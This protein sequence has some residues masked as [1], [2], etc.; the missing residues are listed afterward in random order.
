M[1]ERPGTLQIRTPEGISFS[2]ILASPISRMLAWLIDFA[3]IIGVAGLLGK[4]ASLLS[5]VSADAAEGVYL[6]L[7]FAFSISYGIALEWRWRGQTV[8]KRALRLRVLD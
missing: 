8:G 2:F 5:L 1:L 7:Y 4:A 3:C 6:L